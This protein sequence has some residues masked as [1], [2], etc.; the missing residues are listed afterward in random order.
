M[1]V[2]SLLAQLDGGPLGGIY[3]LCGAA[4][5]LYLSAAQQILLL[6]LLL[7]LS[8]LLVGKIFAVPMETENGVHD[9]DAENDHRSDPKPSA[10][11]NQDLTSCSADGIPGPSTEKSTRKRPAEELNTDEDDGVSRCNAVYICF[12]LI[13]IMSAEVSN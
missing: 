2:C 3:Y 10:V 4:R 8:L 11:V 7:L 5:Y 13:F 12:K 1:I 9:R 6:L